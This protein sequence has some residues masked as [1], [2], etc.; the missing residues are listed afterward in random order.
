MYFLHFFI[1]NEQALN[2]SHQK[3]EKASFQLLFSLII[4][5]KI[6]KSTREVYV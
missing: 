1:N 3:Y 4:L 2:N 5:S 6:L